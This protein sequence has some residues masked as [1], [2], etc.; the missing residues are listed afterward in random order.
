MQ[1]MAGLKQLLNLIPS[2]IK[3]SKEI[4]GEL[5]NLHIFTADALPVYTNTERI[6]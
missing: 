6:V 2:Y 1:H 3:D 4:L 5:E